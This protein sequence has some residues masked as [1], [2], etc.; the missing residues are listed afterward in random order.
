MSAGPPVDALILA[1]G[2][3]SRLGQPKQLVPLWGRALLARAAASARA[4]GA[5]E[6]HA[7]LGACAQACRD[8]LADS[9]TV[10]HEHADWR[11]GQAASLAYGLRALSGDAAVLVMSCD[12]YR[13]APSQV[14]ALID[15]WRAAPGRPCA[16]RY[17]G[18]EGIPV[19]WPPADAAALAAGTRRG[20]D[21]LTAR[22]ASAVAIPEAAFDLDTPQDMAALR[23]YEARGHDPLARDAVRG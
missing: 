16:A 11:R 8:V 4:G 20:Q 3:S 10:L 22:A 9:S 7:V 19:V 15:A 14:A 13:V 5:R 18:I 12:Q 17:A 1:A 21:F 23:E 2:G 6:V